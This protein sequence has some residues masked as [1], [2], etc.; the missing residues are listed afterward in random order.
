MEAIPL[1]EIHLSI[2]NSHI[3]RTRR[4]TKI[5]NPPP[6]PLA[7]DKEGREA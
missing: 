7:E 1:R 6:E 3:D 5:E 4:D 2:R